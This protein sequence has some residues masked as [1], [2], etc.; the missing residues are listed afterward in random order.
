MKSPNVDYL[1]DFFPKNPENVHKIHKKD[2]L[3]HVLVNFGIS[4]FSI[5]PI[6]QYES[7]FLHELFS[8]KICEIFAV[9]Y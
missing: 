8:W 4:N 7:I 6:F 1:P 2:I 3:S 9:N 5:F